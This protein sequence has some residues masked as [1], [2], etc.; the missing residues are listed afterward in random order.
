M[1]SLR[2]SATASNEVPKNPRQR[3]AKSPDAIRIA[4]GAEATTTRTPRRP[5]RAEAVPPAG[6]ATATRPQASPALLALLAE[7]VGEFLEATLAFSLAWRQHHERSDAEDEGDGP[8]RTCA[9]E[10]ES[11]GQL[12]QDSQSRAS[13]AEDLIRVLIDR[14]IEAPSVLARDNGSNLYEFVHR[15]IDA[16]RYVIFLDED[17]AEHE[18]GDGVIRILDK[19]TCIRLDVVGE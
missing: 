6:A 3:P 5:A 18:H 2:T 1:S 4:D 15:S 13:D 9:E 17:T 10:M 19:A 11:L 14:A 16:G 12:V 7:V 8:G